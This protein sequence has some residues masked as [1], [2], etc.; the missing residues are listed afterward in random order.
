MGSGE[1]LWV[2]LAFGTE[3]GF[4][5]HS[6]GNKCSSGAHMVARDITISVGGFAVL[7]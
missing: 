6:Q 1:V 5:A 3:T 2:G 7:T 4:S